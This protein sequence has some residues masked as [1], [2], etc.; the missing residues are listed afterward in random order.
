MAY[1]VSY[2]NNFNKDVEKCRKRG[3]N[4]SRLKMVLDTLIETGT[5]PPSCRPHKLSGNHE[6]ED[7]VCITDIARLNFDN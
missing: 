5:V 2:T 3:Y 7:F 4:M 1:K 6:G